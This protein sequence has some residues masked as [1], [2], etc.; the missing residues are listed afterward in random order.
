MAEFEKEF[1]NVLMAIYCP[2]C[3]IEALTT[4][5][6]PA[7][8]GKVCTIT[9]GYCGGVGERVFPVEWQYIDI[10][11]WPLEQALNKHYA[12]AP[13]SERSDTDGRG[14]LQWD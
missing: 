8:V 7:K 11:A 13:K 5:P 10:N 12:R 1:V 9:C 4:H 6:F 14:V 2:R 3:K